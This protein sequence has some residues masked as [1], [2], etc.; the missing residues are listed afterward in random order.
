[1]A[2]RTRQSDL[3][4]GRFSL[5]DALDI[6]EWLGIDLE[7]VGPEERSDLYMWGTEQGG[8]LY[9]G[10]SESASRV[11]NE[12]R[13]IE[14]AR[15]LIESKQTVI[16]FQAVMIRN[17]AECRRFRFHQETSSLK[18]AKGLLAEYE[19]EGPAVEAFNRNRAPLTTREVEELLIR[20]CV[21]AGAALCNSSCT[22]LWETYLMKR[23]DLLA[24]FALAEMPGFRDVWEL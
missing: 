12:E 3:I 20:I 11:R 21:N 15:K 5:N 10:K 8:I 22:G 4:D 16:G 17:R 18:R 23:T 13:W 19:W 2:T 1:M 14:E 6:V 24:Q 7:E 9:V